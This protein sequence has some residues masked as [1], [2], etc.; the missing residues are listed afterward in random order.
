M[1][2]YTVYCQTAIVMEN[3]GAGTGYCMADR[4]GEGPMVALVR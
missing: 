1:Q 2:D 4:L 3:I